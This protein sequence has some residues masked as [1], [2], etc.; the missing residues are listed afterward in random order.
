M[1]QVRTFLRRYKHYL[2]LLLATLVVFWPLTFGIFSLKNDA[3]VYFLPYR[4]HISE[5]IQH[6]NFPWWN[7]YIYTG[8]PL[9]SDIQSGV[10]NPVV[11]LISLFTTYNMTTL[12]WELLFYLFIGAAGMYKLTRSFINNPA[13]ALV[14]ASAY[15]CSGFMTDGASMVPWITSA[16]YLP[17][18][19]L[20]FYRLLHKP[21]LK[22]TLKFSVALALLITA[23]YPSFFIYS[24]YVMLA[25][26]IAWVISNRKRKKSITPQLVYLFIAGTICLIICSPAILSWWD[27]FGYYDR[28]EGATLSRSLSNPFPPFSSL[29]YLLPSAV[30]KDHPWLLSDISARNASVGIFVFLLFVTSVFRKHSFVQKFILVGILFSFLFSLGNATP[31]REWCY[32]FLPLMDSFRHPSSIRLFTTIGILLMAAPLLNELSGNLAAVRKKL[33]LVCAGAA[34]L[35]V[36]FM[37]F[38]SGNLRLFHTSIG[39]NK[40]FLERLGFADLLFFTGLIQLIFLSIFLFFLHTNRQRIILP[41]IVINSVI[42][43]WIAMPFT[44]ISQVKTA[45]IN[46]HIASFTKGTPLPGNQSTVKAN[47]STF[48]GPYG[49]D[50]FYHK[51]ITI[52]DHVITPTINNAYINFLADKQLRAIVADYPFIYFSDT[53][54]LSTALPDSIVNKSTRIVSFDKSGR[55]QPVYGHTKGS[56][57][58]VHFSYNKMEFVT[59]SESSGLLNIF[60]QFNHNW[61]AKIDDKE[62]GIYPANNAFMT[63]KVPAGKHTVSFQYIPVSP[64]LFCLYLSG[65]MILLLLIYFI[66]QAIKH[67]RGV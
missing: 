9:H 26:T 42:C 12:Q 53:S 54:F 59:T 11:M 34:L 6:G 37:L 66:F 19:F 15:M 67:K 28:G 5:S 58:P 30:Y 14:I 55:H 51:Q 50:N 24:L 8:L 63:I 33:M 3:L 35:I 21:D 2:F 49:Y 23:G 48:L 31:V 13:T 16:A 7:P 57:E 62:T 46:N 40:S 27:F 18:V 45:T 4:Y 43:C 10:W 61:Q 36:T 22:T 38:Y 20:F 60:Q 52:Q 25:G 56:I 41:L 64:I 17:F 65:T 29:S 47:D 44:F 39:L 1:L 32:R